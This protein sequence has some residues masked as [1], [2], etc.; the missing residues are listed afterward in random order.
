M[1]NEEERDIRRCSENGRNVEVQEQWKRLEA[2]RTEG[3]KLLYSLT[4]FTESTTLYHI[5]LLYN[6]FDLESQI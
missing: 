4:C 1:E 2:P 5:T 3:G 6:F